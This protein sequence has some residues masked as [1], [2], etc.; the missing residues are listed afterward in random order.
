MRKMSNVLWYKT[1]VEQLALIK[2]SY[3]DRGNWEQMSVGIYVQ[4]HA[5]V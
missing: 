5:A 4:M 3:I 2:L 1:K